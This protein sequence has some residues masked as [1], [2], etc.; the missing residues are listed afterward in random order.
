MNVFQFSIIC[1]RTNNANNATYYVKLGKKRRES[2]KRNYYIISPRVIIKAIISNII[3][4]PHCRNTDNIIL[5][6]HEDTFVRHEFCKTSL[7]TNLTV[8]HENK[9]RR[10]MH[11]INSSKQREAISVWYRIE[12]AWQIH[13]YTCSPTVQRDY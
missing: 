4:R 3:S 9:T 6:F 7:Q 8:E 2:S 1:K 5:K 10:F 13:V 11:T 12:P